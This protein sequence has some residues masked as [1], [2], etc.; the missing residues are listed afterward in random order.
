MRRDLTVKLLF[1]L[2]VVTSLL[3]YAKDK[4]ITIEVVETTEEIFIGKNPPSASYSAR[5]IMPDGAHASLVCLFP[6]SEGCGRIEPWTL[7]DKT[8]PADCQY[9]DYEGGI[10]SCKRKNLGTY[11]AKRKGDDLLID[12]RKGT[13]RFH[14]ATGPWQ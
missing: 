2:L 4:S 8:A 5:V 10:S 11:R 7:P 3:A 13:V 12:G 14:I 6:T 9:S 1:L